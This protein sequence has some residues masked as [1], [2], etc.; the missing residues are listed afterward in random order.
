MIIFVLIGS[1]PRMVM[2]ARVYVR[3]HS[4]TP[5]CNFFCLRHLRFHKRMQIEI[6]RFTLCLIC[7]FCIRDFHIILLTNLMKLK[8]WF[9]KA[10]SLGL[11]YK[12]STANKYL[13]RYILITGCFHWLTKSLVMH[14]SLTPWSI[15]ICWEILKL[16]LI[17]ISVPLLLFFRLLL[18][19]LL[20][21]FLLILLLLLCLLYTSLLV[22]VLYYILV[23]YS[24]SIISTPQSH[25]ITSAY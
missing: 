4:L 10:E 12:N 8:N 21:I 2:C 20:L 22:L 6:S 11:N 14:L 16:F 23:L 24:K 13:F 1:L 17:P 9:F 18:L 19:L 3:Y 15:D 5:L 7:S 25:T